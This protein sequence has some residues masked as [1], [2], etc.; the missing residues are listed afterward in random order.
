MEFFLEYGLFL[1]KTVTLLAS[2]AFLVV[3]IA[4]T[5]Q[6][7]KKIDKQGRIEIK[8]LNEKYQEM[9]H[10]VQASLLSDADY[11]A[12][13]KAEKKT[14]KA[15]LKESSKKKGELSNRK[16]CLFVIDFSGDIKA[17]AAEPLSEIITA[18]LTQATTEDEIVLRLE[19]A[20][21]MVHSY[22]FAA[23]QLQ[24]IRN[25]N[26]PLTICIDKVAASGGY[27]MAC[28][29]NRIIAAPFAI[30]GSIGVVAQIPNFN[31]LLK[32]HDV[33][34]E[35]LTA[36]EYKRTLTIFGENT[37][38]GREK[39][40]Q[41]IQETH[42]L[43]K[44]FVAD[45][46]PTLDINA[47]ATGETWFGKRALDKG[48]IDDISTSEDYLFS[49]HPEKDIYHVAWVEKHSIADKLGLTA[50]AAAS[51]I[52]HRILGELESRKLFFR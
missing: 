10:A 24:R 3:L 39:F 9:S 23:S 14:E 2:V 41:E 33:D 20:G 30:V 43:F 32:K 18:I 52:F 8:N 36:G 27:M 40:Q 49:H 28:I 34:Y 13:I 35:V 50:E 37:D 19:S 17:S 31:R 45:S 7:A 4:S 29:A 26:I 21:G 46:R 6:R 16:P 48:L 11:E 1:A 5:S 12:V 51:N 22:G 47:V 38:K 25:K 44:E 15:K 42:E